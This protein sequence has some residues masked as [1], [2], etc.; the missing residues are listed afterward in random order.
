MALA[1]VHHQHARRAA[2]LQQLGARLYGRAEHGHVVAERLSE[3]S[4]LEAVHESTVPTSS[5]GIAE[6][7]PPLT[8]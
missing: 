2:F 3:T 6:E 7:R 5:S 4:W 1:R 8:V